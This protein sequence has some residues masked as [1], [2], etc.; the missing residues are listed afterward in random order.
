MCL[1]AIQA[2]ELTD[3]VLLDIYDSV[4]KDA[5]LQA[6]SQRLRWVAKQIAQASFLALDDVVI[7]GA[8][9]QGLVSNNPAAEIVCFVRQLPYKNFQQWLPH[10]LDTLSPVLE[11][12][13]VDCRADRFKVEKDHLR[14]FLAAGPDVSPGGGEAVCGGTSELR[15]KVYISPVFRDSEHLAECLQACP[16]AD[17]LF[18]YP[19]MVRERNDFVGRQP[20]PR[21]VLMRLMMWWASKQL[22]SSAST[23]PSDWLLQQVALHSAQCV[24]QSLGGQASSSSNLL[25][26]VVHMM[27]FCTKLDTCQ[28]TWT[29]ISG[30]L[31]HTDSCRSNGAHFKDALNPHFDMIES[32]GFDTRDLASAAAEPT[33]RLAFQKEAAKWLLRT[34]QHSRGDDEASVFSANSEEFHD[35]EDGHD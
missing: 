10:I 34:G 14:F 31:P 20:L 27:E 25:A 3:E 26:M 22:W 8:A 1:D 6:V 2:I 24:E 19:A 11:A 15:V 17:R 35:A 29:G 33:W 5:N 4:S 16:I 28:V 30:G 18:L 21:R 23:A 7:G 12:T 13:L 32:T 9:A